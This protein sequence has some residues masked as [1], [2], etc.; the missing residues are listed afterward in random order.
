MIDGVKKGVEWKDCFRMELA[1]FAR[2]LHSIFCENTER[3]SV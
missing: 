2:F 1:L 3:R